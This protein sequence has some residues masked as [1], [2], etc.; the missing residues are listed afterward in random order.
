MVT[1]D[2]DEEAAVNELPAGGV[3]GNKTLQLTWMSQWMEDEFN[4][5]EAVEGVLGLHSMC[6]CIVSALLM[7]SNTI[8]LPLFGQVMF[9]KIGFMKS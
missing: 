1:E 8:L 5:E 6:N 7:L 2:K 4:T 9:I 3:E